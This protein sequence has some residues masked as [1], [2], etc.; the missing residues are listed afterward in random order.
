[1]TEI[2]VFLICTCCGRE[3]GC[4]NCYGQCEKCD[5]CER[6]CT[7][8]ETIL[9]QDCYLTLP[10]EYYGFR[11]LKGGETGCKSLVNFSDGLVWVTNNFI[12]AMGKVN[13]FNL[14]GRFGFPHSFLRKVTSRVYKDKQI[15]SPGKDEYFPLNP[16]PYLPS[17]RGTKA[18]IALDLLLLRKAM[19]VTEPLRDGIVRFYIK[20]AHDAIRLDICRTGD[21]NEE[22]MFSIA[23]MPI[24]TRWGS[25]NQDPMKEEPE[26]RNDE[27]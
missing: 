4:A 26:A 21:K 3:D 18:N 14:K 27:T 25:L 12:L 8:T 7:C 23:M 2:G 22:V 15:T 5:K 16:L 13:T 9:E 19:R 17:T 6:H 10:G 20:E 11:H 1:M 24:Y